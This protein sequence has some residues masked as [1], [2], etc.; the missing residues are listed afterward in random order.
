[1]TNHYYSE[2]PTVESNRN[3][4]SFD[5]RGNTLT[6]TSDAGVF[7]KRE[8]DFG[9]R[10]LI[11]VFEWP[12]VKGDLLDMGCGYGPIGLALAKEN[13]EVTVHMADINE[14]AVELANENAIQNKIENVKIVQSNLFDAIEKNDFAAV[15]TNPPIRAGKSTVHEIFEVA[16]SKL[17]AGGQLWVVIQKKQGAPSAIEKLKTLYANVDIVVKKKGYFILRAEKN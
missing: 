11:E 2:K 7:S 1:M 6:F 12:R 13:T 15:L 5:L 14:R 3:T 16:Y 8:V 4:F 9:S 10:L 17:V